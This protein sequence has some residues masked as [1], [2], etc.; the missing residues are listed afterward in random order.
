MVVVVSALSALAG[1]AIAQWGALRATAIL[2]GKIKPGKKPPQLRLIRG[3]R[4]DPDK[5]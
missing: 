3:G 2:L 1:A 5:S 4:T